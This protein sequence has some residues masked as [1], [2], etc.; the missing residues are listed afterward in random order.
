M[1]FWIKEVCK[2]LPCGDVLD[3]G[4]RVHLE[5]KIIKKKRDAKILKNLYK[6]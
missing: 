4:N 5:E 3:G 6:I 2:S 1:D